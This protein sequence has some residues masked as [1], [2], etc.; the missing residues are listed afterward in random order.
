MAKRFTYSNKYKKS[1]IRSLPGPYK[2]LWDFLYHDCDHA[3]IWTVDFETAQIYIG[4]DME[5][6]QKT[7]LEF[8]NADEQRIVILD[9]GKKW[10]LPG[11]IEFQYVKLSETNRAHASA[12]STLK[13]LGLLAP[14]QC[15]KK[16][17]NP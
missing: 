8:F 5:V 12:I 10:F 17:N 4:K 6:D 13:K 7:A 3:G 9:N 15:K 11:F 16:P 2:L 1:F 14:D